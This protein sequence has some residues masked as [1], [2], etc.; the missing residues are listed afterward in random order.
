M[1]IKLIKLVILLIFFSVSV[2]G[3]TEEPEETSESP[4]TIEE[5]NSR[6]DVI[7]FLNKRNM[8][9]EDTWYNTGILEYSLHSIKPTKYLFL[10][11]FKTLEKVDN[12]RLIQTNGQI[13]SIYKD[14]TLDNLS[15]AN[16]LDIFYSNVPLK[17]KNKKKFLFGKVSSVGYVEKELMEVLK[18]ELYFINPDNTLETKVFFKTKNL[19]DLLNK[20]RHEQEKLKDG[21]DYSSNSPKDMVTIITRYEVVHKVSEDLEGTEKELYDSV[22]KLFKDEIPKEYFEYRDKVYPKEKE[23][24]E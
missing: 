3:F 5:Y 23:L 1:N 9:I 20:H 19:T 8:T 2:C 14:I 13:F 16:F 6:P 11:Y 10:M 17:L 12:F 21:F 24:D 22:M 18:L 7:K 15:D 4:M